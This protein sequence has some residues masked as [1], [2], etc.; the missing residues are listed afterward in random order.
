MRRSK[1]VI[2]TQQKLFTN[3]HRKLKNKTDYTTS[4]KNDSRNKIDTD[5]VSN[6]NNQE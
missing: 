3:M 2:E 4:N 1:R 6:D 5:K